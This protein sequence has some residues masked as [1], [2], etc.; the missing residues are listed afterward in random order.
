MGLNVFSRRRLGRPGAAQGD[1]LFDG[2]D[3]DAAVDRS[4][5]ANYDYLMS[6]DVDM[7]D[8]R[9]YDELVHWGCW[10]VD[11]CGLDGFRL[12]TRSSISIAA[13]TC[14]GSPMC[15]SMRGASCLPWASTGTARPTI[16]MAIWAASE[17]CRCSTCRCTTASR[18]HR[19]ARCAVLLGAEP[20][21]IPR[22][23]PAV[24][25]DGYQFAACRCLGGAGYTVCVAKTGGAKTGSAFMSAD[26]CKLCT[27]HFPPR[28]FRHRRRAALPTFS[29]VGRVRHSVRLCRFPGYRNQAVHNL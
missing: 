8:P 14:A 27:A 5:K 10:Y 16:S 2:K 24:F 3:W 7:N 18:R 17:P 6:A 11:A 28:Q 1:L 4:E 9:V 26:F 22:A 19:A 21:I 13:F 15:A 23:E 12:D 20:G 29:Q 25:A